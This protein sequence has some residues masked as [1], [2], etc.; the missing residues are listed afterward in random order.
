MKE[1]SKPEDVDSCPSPRVAASRAAT[2][3]I[4]V[5]AVERDVPE[6]IELPVDDPEDDGY[7]SKLGKPVRDA[8][9][10]TL[11][12][13][14]ILRTG[15]HCTSEVPTAILSPTLRREVVLELG[16][17][18]NVTDLELKLLQLQ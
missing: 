12:K 15:T 4:A 17:F 10:L 8:V 2:N 1:I 6:E 5:L 13:I 16:Q 9:I 11:R 18:V 14:V 3:L 7:S